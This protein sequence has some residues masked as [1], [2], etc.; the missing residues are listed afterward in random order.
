MTSRSALG[1]GFLAMAIAAACG[2]A[3][4]AGSDPPAS[5]VAASAVVM[6]SSPPSPTVT[7]TTTATATAAEGLIA[8][9]RFATAFGAEGFYLG[10]TIVRPDGSVVRELTVPVEAEGLVPIWSPDG[11][12]LALS[13]WTP[14]NGPGWPATIN[15]DGTGFALQKVAGVD[16][17]IGC[18]D[19]SRDGATL[20][21]SVSN[22]H[23]AADGIYTIRVDGTGLT[24]LTTSPFHYTAGVSGGCGGGDGHAVYS[25]DALRIA[26]IRQR[27]GTGDNPSS[28]ES[29][30]IEV[31]DADGG[32]EQEIV[33]QGGVKSHPGTQLSWSPD[34]TLIAFG[35]QQGELYVV[36]PD[37]S[38]RRQIPMP[39]DV[40]AHHA[41]GPDWSPDG[42]RIVFSMYVEAEGASNLYTISPDGSDLVQLTT[43]AGAEAMPSWG[44][45]PEP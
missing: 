1:A 4:P 19:W 22:D 30:A 10:A 34:G 15:A 25:P 5:R 9:D 20:V 8:F 39:A 38:G 3:A 17:G 32:A 28:D 24:R 44:L 23:P 42:K 7:T 37:G 18:T 41:Y 2:S 6:P 43:E 35:S 14:P 11:S 16:G 29:S 27:C 12:R 21:C 31:I 26:F 13:V 33:E 36:K 40:G 45:P